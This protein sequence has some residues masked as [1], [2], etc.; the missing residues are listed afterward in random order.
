MARCASFSAATIRT[1]FAQ[2]TPRGG[3]GA[4]APRR[5]QLPGALA[6]LPDEAEDDVLT[7]LPF[8]AARWWQVWSTNPLGRLNKERKRRIDVID[9]FSGPAAAIRL[10]RALLAE[11]H[12]EWQVG[13]R[14][15]SAESMTPLRQEAEPPLALAA[16]W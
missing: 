2:P 7:Y 15:F 9:T 12:D 16:S 14:Y 11:Q 5:G 1:V 13:R 8:P 3:V 6:A 10:V 4:V